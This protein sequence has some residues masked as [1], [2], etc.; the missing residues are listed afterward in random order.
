MDKALFFKTYQLCLLNV[1]ASYTLST[2]WIAGNFVFS[3]GGWE[4]RIGKGGTLF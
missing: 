1:I 2:N 4:N 3:G